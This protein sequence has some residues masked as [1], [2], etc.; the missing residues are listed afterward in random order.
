MA[1]ATCSGVSQSIQTSST[2]SFVWS[3]R[4][5]PGPSQRMGEN[6]SGTAADGVWGSLMGGDLNPVCASGRILLRR[7][8]PSNRHRIEVLHVKG[9]PT[10]L[11]FSTRAVHAGQKPDP[12]TGAVAVPIYQTSTY[13]QERLGEAAE[14]EYARVQNPTRQALE[15]QV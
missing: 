14:F 1:S 7:P 10:K 12:R 2:G 11:G 15:E 6:G 4:R 3:R 5:S 9:D 8:N 13:V